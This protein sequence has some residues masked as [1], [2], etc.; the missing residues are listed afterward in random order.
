DPMWE[1]TFRDFLRKRLHRYP[2]FVTCSIGPPV[3]STSPLQSTAVSG[4]RHSYRL[5]TLLQ[6]VKHELV[7]QDAGIN[8]CVF[9]LHEYPQ[10]A[11]GVRVGVGPLE[12]E[13]AG[14][15]RQKRSAEPR[16]LDHL[17]HLRK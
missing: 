12:V 4:K 17:K 9:D 16:S 5:A 8:G 14:H 15:V 10:P 11:S 6:N 2:S 3:I 1:H 13:V 7:V